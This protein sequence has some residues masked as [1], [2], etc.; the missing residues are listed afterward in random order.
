MLTVIIRQF[1]LQPARP[2]VHLVAESGEKVTFFREEPI[3]VSSS[4]CFFS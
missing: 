4:E 3:P 2:N 1:G